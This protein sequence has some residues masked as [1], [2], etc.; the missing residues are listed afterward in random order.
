MSKRRTRSRRLTRKE[1]LLA[2]AGAGAGLLTLGGCG[3]G[4]T[5]NA[6]AVGEVAA[7]G[8]AQY[9][10][11][12]VQ[13]GF[14]NGFT[15]GDGQVM[16]EL[17]NRFN[18]EHENID[19]SMVTIQWVDY[20][21]KVPA[22]VA[23][24]QGPDVGV[25]HIDQLGVNAVHGVIVP[26][27]AVAE[28][29]NLQ[30]SDFA[31][32]PWE[33]GVFRGE[34]YGIPLDV[35][36]LGLYYNKAVMDDA[37]LDPESPPQ[38]RE[39]YMQAL[40]QIKDAEIEGSWIPP[41]LFTGWQWFVSLLW[42]FGG[43]LYNEDATR[44]TVDS[45]AGVEALGW[46]VDLIKDGY[47]PANVAQDGDVIAF[48]NDQNAFN[49][50]GIW[51]I[52]EMKAIPELEWGTAPLPQIGTERAAWGQLAQPRAHEPEPGERG[53]AAGVGGVR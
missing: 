32:V 52:N 48:Y 51:T 3:A 23:A 11:P 7:G 10:G 13:L 38:A 21:Q 1:F 14:W 42:Q 50:N 35:H 28:T 46:M 47:S 6:A 30:Q 36:P 15:G 2:S 27:D 25:M 43:S 26:L 5:G 17:V 4:A 40:Q 49:W 12:P 18:S 39:E 29:L 16:R 31:S 34:R 9:E 33:A 44:A 45:E 20:Y 53:Q 8:G 19:V 41:S 22:A 37:G 24:E